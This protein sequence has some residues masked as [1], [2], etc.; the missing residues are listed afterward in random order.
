MK[1]ILSS[2]ILF[3]MVIC[4]QPEQ[5]QAQDQDQDRPTN[6]EVGI[7]VGEPTG[8]S[9][10]FWT[11]DRTAIGLG[12]A[13][14]FGGRGSMHIHGDYLF[15][16]RIEDPDLDFYY[17]L[18]ARLLMRDDAALGIRI[19]LGIQYN[20]PDTNLSAFFELAP[21]LN[22]APATDFDLNGGLGIRYFF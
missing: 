18:G 16:H 15:H 9:G 1:S 10:K 7:I 17:G 19:P 20:I 22:L 14:S 11:S 13:W 3:A 21:M 2:A 6:R 12:L 5:A 8:F 4:F